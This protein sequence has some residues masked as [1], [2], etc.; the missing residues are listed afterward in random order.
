MAIK[1][2]VGLRNPGADYAATRHNVGAWFL[3]A[4]VAS[5]NASF[6]VDKK[7][8]GE[9]ASFTVQEQSCKGLLPL[10]FMN[11]NGLSVQAV[12]QFHRILPEEVL[13]A[14]DEL[15]LEAG[16]VK[17]K[18]GGGHGGHNGLRDVIAHLGS[19]DFHRLR[20]GIGHPGHKTMVLNYVLG[21]PSVA[22]K[23]LMEEAIDRALAIMPTV[24]SG[25]MAIAMG[26]LNG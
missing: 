13:V 19:R 5:V 17:L 10:A 21:K 2:I 12:C 24:L 14:H 18:T 23:Q 20:I 6:A 26:L 16:R 9:I 1:L 3:K 22:D 7:S 15:D 11:L 8:H 4:L 25:N